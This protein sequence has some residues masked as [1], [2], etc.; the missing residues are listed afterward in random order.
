MAA[1]QEKVSWEL[2]T[3]A[4]QEG[5]MVAPTRSRDAE[6]QAQ[7]RTRPRNRDQIR[8]SPVITQQDCSEEAGLR[9]S[10]EAKPAS[11][12]QGQGG[13]PGTVLPAV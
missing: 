11:H 12:S 1:P 2:S 7:V 8:H 9:A 10:Q 6:Q 3:V 4:G 5:A 13:K